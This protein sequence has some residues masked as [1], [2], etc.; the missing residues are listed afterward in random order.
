MLWGH[1]LENKMLLK[2]GE[3]NLKNN[4][5][6]SFKEDGPRHFILFPL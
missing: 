4:F 2:K 6:F 1:F 5:I 3:N